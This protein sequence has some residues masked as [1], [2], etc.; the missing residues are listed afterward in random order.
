MKFN[1]QIEL[2]NCDF[3][4]T[5]LMMF[6]V[7]YH[8]SLFWY[9]NWHGEPVFEVSEFYKLFVMWIKCWHTYAFTLVSGYLFYYLRF[10][11]NKYQIFKDFLCKK[12]CRLLVPAYCVGLLWGVPIKMYLWGYGFDL[13]F[14]FILGLQTS[15]FWFLFMLFDVFVMAYIVGG[16]YTTIGCVC[17]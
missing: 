2:H 4:K 7:L 5:V 1:K 16:L 11:S 13:V 8:S 9:C 6:V 17:F 14:K 3:V 12:I 15:Q 10:E